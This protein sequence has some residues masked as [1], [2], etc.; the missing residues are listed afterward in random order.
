MSAP[1]LLRVGSPEKVFVEA[2]DYNQDPLQV[3]IYVNKFPEI[4]SNIKEMTVELTTANSFQKIVEL[5]VRTNTLFYSFGRLYA[6]CSL[7]M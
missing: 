1:N 6:V 3:T 4:N 5:T 2:Q 7:G